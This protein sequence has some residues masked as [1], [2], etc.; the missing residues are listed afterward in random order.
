MWSQAVKSLHIWKNGTSKGIRD[1]IT[2]PAEIR[3]IRAALTKVW[4]AH[5]SCSASWRGTS[6]VRLWISSNFS[7]SSRWITLPTKGWAQDKKSH[8]SGAY[9]LEGS[10]MLIPAL[11]PFLQTWP[12]PCQDTCAVCNTGQANPSRRDHS[13]LAQTERNNP[14]VGSRE[15]TQLQRTTG[16]SVGVPPGF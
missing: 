3:M 1:I 15:K 2:A 4:C 16:S 5:R 8:L 13:C 7:S 6:W 10:A 14:P 11:Q 9:W 12:A